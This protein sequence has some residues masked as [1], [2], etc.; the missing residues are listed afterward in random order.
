MA[1]NTELS[2]CFKLSSKTDSCRFIVISYNMHGFNQ[3]LEGAKDMIN[4][5]CPDVLALQEHWLSP[6]SLSRLCDISSD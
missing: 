5:I 4:K 3:G 2:D 1:Q 6:T